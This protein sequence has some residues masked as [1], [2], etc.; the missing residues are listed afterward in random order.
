MRKKTLFI[1]VL[2]MLLCGSTQLAFGQASDETILTFARFRKIAPGQLSAYVESESKF[3][4]TVHQGNLKNGV[5]EGWQV[6]TAYAPWGPSQEAD[7]IT[8]RMVKLG[9]G[10]QLPG[11]QG[12]SGA[13]QVRK[14]AGMDELFRQ[15]Q[16]ASSLVRQEMWELVDEVRAKNPPAAEDVLV[17][18]ILNFMKIRPGQVAAYEQVRQD[19]KGLHQK[20]VDAGFMRGWQAYRVRFPGG[21]EAEYD[22][23][24]IDFYETLKFLQSRKLE[25]FFQSAHPGKKFEDLGRRTVEARAIV[26]SGL[27]RVPTELR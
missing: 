27:W 26:R 20:A 17:Y 16:K 1:L 19:W 9:A 6:L 18:A 14:Q 12:G 13:Q 22:F 5:M 24:T 3:W 23:V 8:F 4:K 11:G 2:S 10:G 25:E 21:T 15:G 7:A